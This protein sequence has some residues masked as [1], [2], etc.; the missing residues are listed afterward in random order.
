MRIAVVSDS[1][2]GKYH[3]ERFVRFCKAENIQQVCHLGDVTEDAHYLRENL[4]IPVALVAGNCDF[5]SHE[6][7]EISFTLEGVRFLLVHGDR[8]GVKYGYDRLSYY[9]EEKMADCTLFGHTHRA[10]AGYVGNA[11]LVN[12][13][14][15]KNGSLCLLEVNERDITPRIMDIDKWESSEKERLN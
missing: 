14:A 7:R 11:L 2:G 4:D 12:P 6:P 9:A 8:F 15:L 10:F 1:H 5:Y 3:L 13:G